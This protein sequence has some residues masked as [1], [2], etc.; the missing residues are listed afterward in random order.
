V[1][2]LGHP[3]TYPTTCFIDGGCGASVFAH[4]NGNGDFVL[5]DELRPPWPIHSCYLNRFCPAEELNGPRPA[6]GAYTNQEWALEVARH[7]EGYRE[8][9]RRASQE[10]GEKSAR[11]IVKVEP[12][13]LAQSSIQ[14]L[15]WVQDIFERRAEKLIRATGELAQQALRKALGN[16]TSQITVV[17]SEFKSYTMFID[18]HQKVI[19]KRSTVAAQM[20]AISLLGL[21]AV[22]VCDEIDIL[23][24]A[25]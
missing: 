20:R 13:D 24:L 7:N 21:G 10:R 4:T 23:P 1:D 9:A 5:F 3:L 25:N 16:R 6:S 18:I 11:T 12:S 22:F 14:V 19:A 2:I 17:D 8:A 15:G